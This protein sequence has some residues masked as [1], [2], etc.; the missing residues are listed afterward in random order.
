MWGYIFSGAHPK[1]ECVP[2]V[3]VWNYSASSTAKMVFSIYRIV[4]RGAANSNR[5]AISREQLRG[6]RHARLFFGMRCRPFHRIAFASAPWSDEGASNTNMSLQRASKGLSFLQTLLL[7][8]TPPRDPP[9]TPPEELCKTHRRP[10][11]HSERP[12]S[13]VACLLYQ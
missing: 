11:D 8:S 4:F 1:R 6:F 2:C 7:I 9:E 10:L 3:T 13:D 5:R 12:L